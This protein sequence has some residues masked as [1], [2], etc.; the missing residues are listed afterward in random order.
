[1][2]KSEKRLTSI[3]HAAA[4]SSVLLTIRTLVLRTVKVHFALGLGLEFLV[5][6][7]IMVGSGAS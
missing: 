7:C 6:A 3:K 4:I 1:M 5:K 2:K